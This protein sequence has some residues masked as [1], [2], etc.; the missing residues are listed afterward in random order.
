MS[1]RRRLALFRVVSAAVGCLI[2]YGLLEGLGALALRSSGERGP[3]LPPELEG[4]VLESGRTPPMLPDPY[5]SYRPEP[6]GS[7]PHAHVNQ[8]G[9][10]GPETTALPA[11]GVYRILLLGG[12]VAWGYTAVRDDETVSAFLERY[13]NQ[14]RD[15]SPVLR[16]R[17]VEVLNAGVPGYVAWQGALA[18]SLRHRKLAPRLVVSLD[19]VNE[20]EAA[21]NTGVAGVPLRFDPRVHQGSTRPTLLGGLGDWARY[22]LSRL[23]LAKYLEWRRRPT[24]AQR[25]PPPAE[26][27]AQRYGEALD[28]LAD[29]ASLEGAVVVPVLQPLAILPGSKPLGDFERELVEHHE[30][31]LPGI[32][33]GFAEVYAASHR[34]FAE[35]A[36]RRPEVLPFDATGVFAREPRI[37]YVDQCHLT[38]LGRELLAAAIGDW[39][40]ERLSADRRGIPSGR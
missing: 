2:G 21:V 15:R 36:A 37:T 22:R 12:S 20:Y 3:A 40:L 34:V 27:V 10:R 4:R 38:P 39:I 25:R 6:G 28:Y 9:L 1:E 11:P 35:L 29:F 7:T 26:E 16:D 30:R 8:L 18:Y 32:N 33:A 23:Q 24:L 14:H 31:N 17:S 19:G 5:L 13:L